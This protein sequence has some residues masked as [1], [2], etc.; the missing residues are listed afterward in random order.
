MLLGENLHSAVEHEHV[1]HTGFLG[2]LAL[3][4]DNARLREIVVLIAALRDAIRQVD[5]LTVHEKSLVQKA[6]F[7]QSLAPHEHECTRQNFHLVGLVI[8]KMAHV[9]PRETLAVREKLAQAEHLIKRRC[10]RRQTALRLRQELSLAINHLHT[11]TTRVR[12]AIHKGDTFAEGVVL[13]NSIGVQQEHILPCRYADSLVVGLGKTYIVL[14]GDNLHLRKLLRQHLQR[15]V[16][17]VVINDKHFTLNALHG[18]AHRIEALFEEVFDVVV[19]DDDRELHA[20]K[21]HFGE[22]YES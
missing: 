14:V 18:A 6:N 15:T 4:V 9:I 16:N 20:L 2:A 12:V 7:V 22:G 10:W 17:G 13:D 1:I 21:N 5:V 8:G 3:V 11:K 19:D